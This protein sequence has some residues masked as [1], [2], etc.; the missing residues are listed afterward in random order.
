[1]TYKKT[2]W[3]RV[4]PYLH[5]A[6]SC[7]LGNGIASLTDEEKKQFIRIFENQNKSIQVTYFIPA[8]GSGSRMFDTVFNFLNSNPPSDETIEFVE[9]LIN[10]AQNFAFYN[11]LRNIKDDLESGNLDIQAFLKL[12]LFENGFNF[13]NL[14]KG[15]IPF[16]RYGNFI[17]N[18][19]Q[20]HILQGVA[21]SGDKSKFH[22]YHQSGFEKQIHESVRILKEITGIDF[23]HEFS[24]QNPATDAIAF[25]QNL[26]PILDSDGKSITRPAGHG[27]LLANLNSIDSDL[28]FIRN[29]DNIQHQKVHPI[30]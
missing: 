23:K 24:V 7:R 11:K 21:I 12:L 27:A 22:L 29:I 5:L 8:S 17:V 6:G 9:H 26:N 18:P 28:V 13:G 4:I 19:F 1:M 14:P 16:H 10:S 20:E 30:R 3:Q 25:D 15:L 2:N